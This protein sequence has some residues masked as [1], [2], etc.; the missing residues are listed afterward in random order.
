MKTDLEIAQ[1]TKVLP[2]Q[3]IARKLQIPEAELY[4]YGKDKAKVNLNYLNDLKEKKSHLI[5]V[6]GISPTKAGEGKSTVTIGLADGLNAKGK[7]AMVCLREPSMGPVFGLKGGATGGGYSQVVP[8]ESINLHFTGDMHAITAANNLIAA[9][10]DNSI[11]QDNPLNIDP[12]TVV[13]KRCLDMNDRTLRDITIA[14]NKKVNGIE[15]QDHFVITVA[16]E[17]MAILCLA[18]SLSDLQK[19]IGECVLAYTY[20]KKPVT[21]KQIQADGAATLLLKEALMP[22]LVQTLEGTPAFV[23]GGPFAN[24]AH[25][26]NSIIATKSALKLSD[27]VITEAGFGADLGAEKFFDIKCRM[28][29]LKPSATVIVATIRALKLH[30]GADANQLANEDLHALEKGLVNLERHIENLKSFGVPVVIANNRFV[31][32]TDAE[33][34]FLKKWAK[35][36][37][38]PFALSEGW[39][40]GSNGTQD[41]VKEVLSVCEQVTN[42]KPLYELNQSI[43]EKIETIAKKIYKAKS[44]IYSPEAQASLQKMKENSWDK[45]AICMAKT[46]MSFSDNPKLMGAPENFDLH[47]QDIRVSLGAGFLVVLTGSIMV[48]PGLPKVPAANRMGVDERGKSF[49]LF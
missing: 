25:G 46:P 31:T 17:M 49:G 40:K 47:V 16:S 15:R 21:V 44:V 34:A 45:L 37:N 11:Y 8:M 5:L 41:L 12:E 39:A 30:G 20:E 48:M 43:E 1:E 28:A 29:D 26:C 2:I 13:W 19:R 18:T 10:L 24:I 35:E 22:N 7:Q 3:K 32:D 33:L 14:Q 6:T 27:Y 23:H 42:F 9:M 38:Y 36:K 4:L